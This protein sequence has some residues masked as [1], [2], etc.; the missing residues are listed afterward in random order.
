ML[1]SCLLPGG[2]GKDLEGFVQFQ[3]RATECALS[4]SLAAQ[5]AV[6]IWHPVTASSE[7]DTLYFPCPRG[8]QLGRTE[9][10]LNGFGVRPLWL[11]LPFW[12]DVLLLLTLS[13]TGFGLCTV[14]RCV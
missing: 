10:V 14:L 2:G 1:L 9:P 6:G 8:R 7:T 3:G 11:E 4:I 13:F 5:H 12:L